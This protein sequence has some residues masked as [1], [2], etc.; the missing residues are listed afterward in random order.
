MDRRIGAVALALCLWASGVP[1]VRAEDPADAAR[2]LVMRGLEQA[3][4]GQL[5]E[6]FAKRLYAK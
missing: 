3:E 2:D 6:A 4:A 1:S 5:K